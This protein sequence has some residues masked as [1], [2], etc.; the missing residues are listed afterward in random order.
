MGFLQKD[1]ERVG[2]EKMASSRR[3]GNR[4]EPPLA[5]IG[6]K[7]AHAV[8]GGREGSWGGSQS[9]RRSSELRSQEAFSETAKKGK[10]GKKLFGEKT[11]FDGGKYQ[12]VGSLL[13]KGGK[14]IPIIKRGTQLSQAHLYQWWAQGGFS[15]CKTT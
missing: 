12:V 6:G 10:R 14:V 5:A 13:S 3:G 9:Q 15:C 2:H 8:A 11:Y 7:V 4:I 1:T